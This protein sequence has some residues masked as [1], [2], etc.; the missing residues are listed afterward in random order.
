MIAAIAGPIDLAE[1]NRVEF[2]LMALTKSLRSTKFTIMAWREGISK[3]ETSPKTNDKMIKCQ[4]L[5]NPAM[6]KQ[7]RIIA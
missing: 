4:I 6:V 7:A 1:L 5:I 3:A 2:K